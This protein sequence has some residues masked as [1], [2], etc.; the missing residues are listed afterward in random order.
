MPA[1]KV[2]RVWLTPAMLTC[3]GEGHV[4]SAFNHVVNLVFAGRMLTL[5]DEPLPDMPDTMYLP[6]AGLRLLRTVREAERVTW[7]RGTLTLGTVQ[8]QFPWPPQVLTPY[9]PEPWTR[10]Y[11]RRLLD[12]CETVTGPSGLDRLPP[13][14]LARV[15]NGLRAYVRA[16]LIGED[17]QEAITPILGLGVGATP[18]A[19]DAILAVTALLSFSKIDF[20]S[21][22]LEMTSAVS[23]KYLCCAKE[24][25]YA[26]PL[27][28]LLAQP[29]EENARALAACGGTSGRDMLHG[30]RVA[31]RQ[32]MEEE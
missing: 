16:L 7:H 1:C 32:L 3:Q 31:C 29:T 10:A 12:A 8:L 25:Y 24:G 23:A 2:S 21:R 20:P 5:A 30:L 17:A 28:R 9:Q 26:E 22:L 14:W 4:H 13:V 15:D 6:A 18:S 11:A 27:T 19:D